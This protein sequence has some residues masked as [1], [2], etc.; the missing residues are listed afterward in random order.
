[1][2]KTLLSLAVAVGLVLA[3]SGPALA[4][5]NG[6]PDCAGSFGITGAN[7][8]DFNQNAA[9]FWVGVFGHKNRG[10][11]LSSVAREGGPGLAAPGRGDNQQALLENCG[12]GSEALPD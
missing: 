3:L 8:G 11:W 6:P 2:T 5:G 4:Q 7:P 10:E 1:M 12:V 9:D